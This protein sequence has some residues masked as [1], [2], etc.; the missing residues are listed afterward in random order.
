MADPFQAV[1]RLAPPH[2]SSGH[3]LDARVAQNSRQRSTVASSCFVGCPVKDHM[4]SKPTG[5]IQRGQQIQIRCRPF[6][7]QSAG[8][9]PVNPQGPSSPSAS[10]RMALFS[11]LEYTKSPSLGRTRHPE[12]QAQLPGHQRRP[13]RYQPSTSGSQDRPMRGAYKTPP[14]LLLPLRQG[15]HPQGWRPQ[16]QRGTPP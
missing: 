5:L 10:L 6:C 12:A 15:K 14:G 16:P 7:V 9:H 4:A 2:R 8:H 13:L 1:H 3:S 11:A